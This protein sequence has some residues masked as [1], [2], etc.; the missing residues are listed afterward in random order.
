MNKKLLIFPARVNQKRLSVKP[1]KSYF[2]C[3]KAHLPQRIFV[4]FAPTGRVCLFPRAS[5]YP[6]GPY[7][8]FRSFP[9]LLSI[10][11]SPTELDPNRVD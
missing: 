9:A 11:K 3:G 5:D 8:V 10:Y 4:L 7:Q 2:V 6:S 1:A